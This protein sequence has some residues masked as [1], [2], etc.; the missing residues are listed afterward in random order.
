MANE[1]PLQ[2]IGIISNFGKPI[3][4]EAWDFVLISWEY[5]RIL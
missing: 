3:E 2:E 1:N 5:E 4:N